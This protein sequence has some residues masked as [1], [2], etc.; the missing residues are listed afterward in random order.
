VSGKYGELDS[1]SGQNKV[2]PWILFV[3]RTVQENH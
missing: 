1:V 3:L 2:G